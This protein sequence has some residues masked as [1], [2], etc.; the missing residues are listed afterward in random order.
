MCAGLGAVVGVV[1]GVIERF[2]WAAVASSTG[3]VT[4]HVVHGLTLFAVVVLAVLVAERNRRRCR[5]PLPPHP[6]RLRPADRVTLRPI[7][8]DQVGQVRVP[9]PGGAR[10]VA[11]AV[12]DGDGLAP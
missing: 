9:H 3:V 5:P 6:T 8:S 1:A 11:E 12:V 10:E 7:R 2:A 4:E